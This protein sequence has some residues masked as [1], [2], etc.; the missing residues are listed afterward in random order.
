MKKNYWRGV[1]AE[2]S[3]GVRYS[4][5]VYYLVRCCVCSILLFVWLVECI[6]PYLR[7]IYCSCSDDQLKEIIKALN[8]TAEEKF[9]ICELPRGNALFVKNDKVAYVKDLVKK[10]FESLHFDVD[11]Q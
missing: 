9:L 1:W 5:D 2:E 6:H 8:A 3:Y 10:Y 11:K 7:W 4:G